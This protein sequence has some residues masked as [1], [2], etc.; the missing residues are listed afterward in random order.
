MSVKYPRNCPK[1]SKS[2]IEKMLN[3]SPQHRVGGGFEELKKHA[4]FDGINWKKLREKE[5]EVFY[6]P[7]E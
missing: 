4:F 5:L 1:S 7:P 3:K 2:F 6:K